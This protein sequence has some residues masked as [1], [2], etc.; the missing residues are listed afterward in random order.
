MQRENFTCQCC[1]DKDSTLNVHHTY[2]E[3]GAMPWEYPSESLRCFCEICHELAQEQMTTMR[4]LIGTLPDEEIDRVIGFIKGILINRNR[5]KKYTFSDGLEADGIGRLWGL[6]GDTVCI[7]SGGIGDDDRSWVDSED[8]FHA[9]REQAEI[10]AI[11]Q[12]AGN[13]NA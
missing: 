11:Q 4:R 8:L 3:K 12:E 5:G 1:G 9:I 6:S 13:S 7:Y 10:D 2:Y